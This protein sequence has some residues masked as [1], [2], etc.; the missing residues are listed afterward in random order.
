MFTIALC[1]P[2]AAGQRAV[3]TLCE[4]YFAQRSE[5]CRIDAPAEDAPLAGY[6]LIFLSAAGP[7]P[8]G[9][10]TAAALRRA[11]CRASV[12]FLAAGPEYAM[13]AFGV[14]ALQ[15]FIPPVPAARLAETLDRVLL[16][17]RGPALAVSAKSGLIRIGF[18]EIEYVE[19]TDHILHFHLTDGRLVRS[20]TLRVPLGAALAPL[21]ADRRFYQPHRSYVVNLDAVRLLTEAEFCMNGGAKVPVPKGRAAQAR[22]AFRAAAELPYAAQF[23]ERGIL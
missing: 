22:A 17:R 18:S 7:R 8:N 19:C 3:R 5:P 20:T 11:G 15:Y 12:V 6:D 2:G 16:I 21:L 23:C 14:S 13:D 1:L 10:D 9:I 4:E